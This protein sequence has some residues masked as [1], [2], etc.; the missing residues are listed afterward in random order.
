VPPVLLYKSNVEVPLKYVP[1]VIKTSRG[2][3]LHFASTLST[4]SMPS[5]VLPVQA[6]TNATPSGVLSLHSIEVIITLF[7]GGSVGYV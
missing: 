2:N 5:I 3:T 1:P 4:P 6:A 7:P